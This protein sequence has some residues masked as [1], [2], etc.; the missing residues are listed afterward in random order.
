MAA[1]HGALQGNRGQVTRLGSKNSGISSTLKTWNGE[2]V[3]TL[4]AD[5]EFV[6]KVRPFNQY[7]DPIARG[8]VDTGHVEKVR[9]WT[10]KRDTVL[11][12]DMDGIIQ[13]LTGIE[14]YI[15]RE[16]EENIETFPYSS[17]HSIGVVIEELQEYMK[18][19]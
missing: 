10:Y 13:L 18:D 12:T 17:L 9:D 11:K 7:G 6:V 16:Y 4:E 15:D 14:S 2:I 3:T 5:G 8:N 1:L 19:K